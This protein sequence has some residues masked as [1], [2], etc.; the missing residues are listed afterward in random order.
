MK[1]TNKQL[2]Q[3]IKEEMQG[4]LNEDGGQLQAV[5]ATVEYPDMVD[6]CR[7]LSI[8]IT[9]NTG[10]TIDIECT[11]M[12]D[13]LDIMDLLQGDYSGYDLKLEG[14]FGKDDGG[15]M[16]QVKVP[17]GTTVGISEELSKEIAE[18]VEDMDDAFEAPDEGG[19]GYY[20]Y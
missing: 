14:I 9:L 2:K 12:I 5:S 3:I 18:E 1:L 13:D 20:D 11:G 7:C 19:R 15:K 4:V 16:R 17:P 8:E 10:N 6:E